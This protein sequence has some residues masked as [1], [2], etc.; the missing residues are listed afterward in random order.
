MHSWVQCVLILVAFLHGRFFSAENVCMRLRAFSFCRRVF[1]FFRYPPVGIMRPATSFVRCR[2]VLERVG[3]LSFTVLQVPSQTTRC[4]PRTARAYRRSSSRSHPWL[5]PGIFVL[6]S[7][8]S[9]PLCT[10]HWAN[11]VQW[12]VYPCE[13]SAFVRY[14]ENYPS[15]FPSAQCARDP[16][17]QQR[18]YVRCEVFPIFLLTYLHFFHPSPRSAKSH[19]VFPLP[20]AFSFQANS[21][22]LHG[23]GT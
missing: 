13:R 22:L 20:C 17:C 9:Q 1:A 7:L 21:G 10:K 11:N 8:V 18:G 15:V 16:G 14:V 4:I 3:V 23:I 12:R 19:V 5:D 6:C 2:I